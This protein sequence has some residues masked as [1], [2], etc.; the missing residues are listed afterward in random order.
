ME[1]Q[2]ISG[3]DRFKD[4][5]QLQSTDQNTN[6]LI[7]FVENKKSRLVNDYKRILSSNA[8]SVSPFRY[9]YKTNINKDKSTTKFTSLTK[10]PTYFSNINQIPS[11]TKPTI[12]TNSK[13]P[14]LIKNKSMTC[15]FDKKSLYS[16]VNNQAR[17]IISSV[18]NNSHTHSPKSFSISS[19][20]KIG[21]MINK[22]KQRLI[23]GKYE[24][25][26]LVVNNISGFKRKIKK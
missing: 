11:I 19:N 26:T 10:S 20:T 8:K 5:E 2:N 4:E 17:S 7:C 3:I 13:N 18:Y 9:S 24:E 14:S 25:E 22:T 6:E 15:L 1:I 16:R 23:Q 21:S 12:K